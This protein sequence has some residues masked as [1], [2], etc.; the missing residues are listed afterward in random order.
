MAVAIQRASIAKNAKT[1]VGPARL[2]LATSW[3]VAAFGGV[4]RFAAHC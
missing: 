2:E 1:L 3:F 4:G